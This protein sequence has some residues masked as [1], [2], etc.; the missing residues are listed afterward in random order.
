MSTV[1]GCP[2]FHWGETQIVLETVVILT[3]LSAA[4]LTLPHGDWQTNFADLRTGA[5]NG[6]TSDVFGV[7]SK[8]S[9]LSSHYLYI[10]NALSVRQGT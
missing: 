1:D 9:A 4:K 7:S 10:L 3:N 5:T 6:A 8:I 2:G